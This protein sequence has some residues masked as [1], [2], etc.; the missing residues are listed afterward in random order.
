MNQI[1]VTAKQ[2]NELKRGAYGRGV[3]VG[4]G[5]GVQKQ[6]YGVAKGQTTPHLGRLFYSIINITHIFI[7]LRIVIYFLL[8]K[9]GIS[10]TRSSEKQANIDAYNVRVQLTEYRNV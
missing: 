1:T 7:C 6:I 2:T 3:G 5:G 4:G 10:Y 9:L 8:L